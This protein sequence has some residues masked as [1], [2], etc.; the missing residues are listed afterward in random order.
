MERPSWWCRWTRSMSMGD[1]P[2]TR[3]VEE[4]YSA[5]SCIHLPGQSPPGK[6]PTREDSLRGF[7]YSLS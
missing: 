3:L 6:N 7:G 5:G 1:L 2:W 4:L